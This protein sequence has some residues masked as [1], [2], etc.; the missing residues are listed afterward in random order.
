[1]EE[2][3]RIVAHAAVG[4]G[5]QIDVS[6]EAVVSSLDNCDH[7]AMFHISICGMFFFSLFCMRLYQR[8]FLLGNHTSSNHAHGT[9][10]PYINIVRIY[11]FWN[12]RNLCHHTTKIRHD[13]LIGKKIIL[14]SC[15]VLSLYIFN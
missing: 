13:M 4:G 8:E 11:Q 7:H 15:S 1:M 5:P 6:S 14:F 3:P 12:Y 9:I 2:D 10:R